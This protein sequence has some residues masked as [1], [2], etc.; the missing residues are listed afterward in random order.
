MLSLLKVMSNNRRNLF[1]PSNR[2]VGLVDVSV[3]SYKNSCQR[4]V[5]IT[6]VLAMVLIEGI[7]SKTTTLSAR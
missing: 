2:E 6:H 3:C 7:P 5:V 4:D 1:I